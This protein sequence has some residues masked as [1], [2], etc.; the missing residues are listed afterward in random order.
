M[1]QTEIPSQV[2]PSESINNSLDLEQELASQAKKDKQH[3]Y[4]E[5]WKRRLAMKNTPVSKTEEDTPP[6]SEKNPA[7]S[8]SPEVSALSEP[9]TV[10]E[11]RPKKVK[12][13]KKSA[14]KSEE[15]KEQPAI[16]IKYLL[17]IGAIGISVVVAVLWF[18]KSGS[19]RSKHQNM[20]MDLASLMSGQ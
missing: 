13:S 10:L 11:P 2:P 20:Q 14:P 4:Y 18:Q 1:S 3:E 6:K 16:P 9:V 17:L 7:P 15:E 8:P 19:T 12:R 5:N